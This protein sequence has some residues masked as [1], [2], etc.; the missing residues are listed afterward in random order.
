MLK[1][2]VEE[3]ANFLI[4]FTQSGMFIGF[5]LIDEI[6]YDTMLPN[7]MMSGFAWWEWILGMEI[8]AV[9]SGVREDL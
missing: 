3:L 8:Q 2:N 9:I 4:V 7:D 1:A 6:T 5:Q